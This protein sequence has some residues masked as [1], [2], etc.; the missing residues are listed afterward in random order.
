ML[1]FFSIFSKGGILLWCFRGIGIDEK[2][3][4]SFTPAINSFIKTFLLQVCESVKKTN[5]CNFFK[6]ICLTLKYIFLLDFISK[7]ATQLFFNFLG[8]DQQKCSL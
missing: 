5:C 3:W 1:D 2:D 6:K 8:K 7:K 4:D